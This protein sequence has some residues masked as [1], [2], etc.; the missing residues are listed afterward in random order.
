MVDSFEE[1]EDLER[2]HEIRCDSI[3]H[4]DELAF[5]RVDPKGLVH[6]KLTVI[7]ALVEVAIVKDYAPDGVGLRHGDIL[8]QN[9]LESRVAGQ[10]ALH[11]NASVNGGVDDIA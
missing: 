1:S 3:V 6:E 4:D 7:H 2:C 5:W 10:V 11:L 8:T 9:E